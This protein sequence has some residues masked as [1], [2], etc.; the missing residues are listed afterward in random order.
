MPSLT[1]DIS[2]DPEEFEEAVKEF[3]SRR[4]VSRTEADTIEE[5]AR[6]RA[7]W[8]SGVAQ[9]DVV[10]DQFESITKAMREGT[11]FEAWRKEAAPKLEKAWGRK[12]APWIQ[13]IFR[14]ANMQAYNAGRWDQMHEPH[15]LAVRPFGMLDVVNDSRTS[16]VCK[17]FL[18]PPI[19]IPLD[20][21]R[22]Q[23]LCPPF[24]HGCRTGV[25]TLRRSTAEELGITQGNPDIKVDTGWGYP[26]T[27]SEPRKPSEREKQPDPDIQVEMAAKAGKDVRERKP[28]KIDIPKELTH[29]HWEEHYREKYGEA[30]PQ[31]AWGRMVHERAKIMDATEASDILSELK[32]QKVPGVDPYQILKLKAQA[33]GRTI[34]D[35]DFDVASGRLLAQH[36]KLC[37]GQDEPEIVGEDN[38]KSAVQQ[39]RAWWQHM[40]S[41][42]LGLPHGIKSSVSYKD[43][44]RAYYDDLDGEIVLGEHNDPWIAVHEFGHG[45]ETRGGL[46]KRSREFV[47]ARTIGESAQPLSVLKNNPAYLASEFAKPDKFY[48]AYIGKAYSHES[49]EVLSTVTGDMAREQTSRILEED[50]ESLYFVLGLLAGVP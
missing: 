29:E 44:F 26:P 9:M 1:L 27:I 14:N 34:F 8:I 13:L 21:P 38:A 30:A 17:K 16:D 18:D 46:V 10:Q 3:S 45:V 7:W 25:R 48:E 47:E 43:G 37:R 33:S 32:K 20:D 19:I 4:V 23:R 5:Y 28:K 40:S 36:T 50:P 31:V 49:T 24:H 42:R 41:P 35:N 12:N 15:I 39:A 2:A 6:R 22:W 11:P